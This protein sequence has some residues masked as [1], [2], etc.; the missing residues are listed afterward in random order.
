MALQ[1]ISFPP[2]SDLFV[3]LMVALILLWPGL[4]RRDL[5]L[6]LA[7]G[8]LFLH[9]S[10]SISNARL[11][12]R[13]EGDS[14][15]TTI[16]IEEFPT[17]R[18]DVASF[19]A[20]AIG[21]E[22]VR[23]RLRLTWLAPPVEPRIGDVWR[24]EIRLRRPHGAANPGGMDAEAWLHRERIGGIGYVVSG[25]RTRLLDSMTGSGLSRLRARYVDEVE[26]A[27]GRT[28]ASAVILAVAVGARHRMTAGQWQRYAATGT[29]HLMAIS[30]LHVGL[31][32][33]FTYWHAVLLFGV[34]GFGQPRRAA[35]L[36]SM[37]VAVGYSAI[38]GFAVP[39][40]RA[41][42]MLAL[43]TLAVASR[44]EFDGIRIVAMAATV[45]VVAAPVSTMQP[46]FKL[47]F[48]AV[49][50]LVWWSRHS[51]FGQRRA[52][53]LIDA[54][55]M[56][57]F[58]L[59]PLTVLLFDR[60]SPVS[61]IIN[62]VAVPIFSV[63]TVPAALLS[64]VLPDAA[65]LLLLKLAS[66]SV[67]VVDALAL[68]VAE[69][70]AAS[71][72]TALFTGA[73]VAFVVLPVAW[74]MPRGW[75]GRHVAA[76]GVAAILLWRPPAVPATCIDVWS[77]DVGHGLAVAVRSTD[78]LLLYDTGASWR[79][80]DSAAARTIVPW[81]RAYGIR[82]IDQLVVSHA[83]N[84]HAGG[85]AELLRQVDVGVL[86]SGEPMAGFESR[87][88]R[89]G[90]TWQWRDASFRVLH[91]RDTNTAGNDASCVVLVSIG[92][93]HVLLTGDIEAATESTLVRSRVLPNVDVVT[94]PHHG[95]LTS[96]TPAFVAA[97]RP[98]I[99]IVSAARG[100]H[101]GF[102][103]PHVVARWRAVGAQV[104]NTGDSG[105]IAVRIC[106][107]SGVEAPREW[108]EQRRRM[109]HDPDS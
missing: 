73:A 63:I 43:A 28:E 60:I 52:F 49:L 18:R 55:F 74:L 99:A 46:G 78:R 26:R 45:I 61:P 97:T 89:A 24:V 34:L 14:L 66:H 31:A 90:L 107:D 38:A 70:P 69:H 86:I 10:S 75:P 56:L 64:I 80:G 13:F 27:L 72:M 65:A 87:M 44:R 106:R 94:I 57:F 83:D 100:N 67:A 84:D 88:C 41:V 21:D 102:P 35:L 104:I 96:S 37:L 98:A 7:G 12:P 16:R 20:V 108:R 59:L 95:S 33:L 19:V 79:H 82:R 23:S 48:A 3:A 54:Q 9:A 93:Y 105:A 77:L 1:L 36:V 58:A 11:E 29:S 103:K 101:W 17:I 85:V 39:S 2:G 81:L 68:S 25:K 92:A 53:S 5:V 47:S 50:A 30:G 42:L 22:R 62:L 71:R 6:V 51:R 15:L 40:Q 76:V 4:E 91:P 32:A 8:A 109:W